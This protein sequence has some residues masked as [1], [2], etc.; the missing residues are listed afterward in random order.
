MSVNDRSRSAFIARRANAFPM[1][2]I[3]ARL[4]ATQAI[5]HGIASFATLGGAKDTI[6]ASSIDKANIL[7]AYFKY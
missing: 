2:P 7:L 3:W 6:T 1:A 4:A 5:S